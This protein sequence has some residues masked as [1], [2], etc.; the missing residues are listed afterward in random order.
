MKGKYATA[1]PPLEVHIL[2]EP[3]LVAQGV[4]NLLSQ[5]YPLEK[6]MAT[7]SSILAWR[8][9]WLEEYFA[10]FAIF[11]S[12]FTTVGSELLTVMKKKD[13]ANIANFSMNYK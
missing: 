2:L 7:H 8:I 1:P 12:D 6:G 9:P 13:A 3:F 5:E 11:Y 4:K 10:C